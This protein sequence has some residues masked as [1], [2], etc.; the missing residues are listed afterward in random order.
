MQEFVDPDATIAEQAHQ[1]LIPQ[2][3]LYTVWTLFIIQY[4]SK[5]LI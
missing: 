5:T 3:F 4:H 2:N 1:E